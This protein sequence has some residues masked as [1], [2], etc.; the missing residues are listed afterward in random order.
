MAKFK[1]FEEITSWQK[2]RVFTKQIYEI[3]EASKCKKDID[4]VR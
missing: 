1:S 2:S 3:T 4:F